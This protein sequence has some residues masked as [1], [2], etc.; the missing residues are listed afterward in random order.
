MQAAD[1]RISIQ[2]TVLSFYYEAGISILDNQ[3]SDILTISAYAISEPSYLEDK[4][5]KVSMSDNLI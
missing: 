3:V 1:T 4:P 2:L 5:T